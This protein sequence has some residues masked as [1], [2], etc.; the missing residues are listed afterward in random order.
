MK[1]SNTIYLKNNFTPINPLATEET[2]NSFKS[3]KIAH[4]E[5]VSSDVKLD[6]PDNSLTYLELKLDDSKL[7][8]YALA[9][10]NNYLAVGDPEANRVVVYSR[11]TDNNWLRLYEIYPPNNSLEAKRKYGFGY[12]IALHDNLL[13]IYSY[14]YEND[15][16]SLT[17]EKTI[18]DQNIYLTILNHSLSSS[19]TEIKNPK[20]DLYYNGI[21]FLDD[22]VALIAR[23][24]GFFGK[25]STHILLIHP[26]TGKTVKNIKIQDSNFYNLSK[27]DLSSDSDNKSI[28]IL[29]TRYHRLKYNPPLSIIGDGK[30]KKII[31]NKQSIDSVVGI[32]N[33]IRSK[34]I[35]LS[36]DLILIGGEWG[37]GKLTMF[38]SNSSQPYLINFINDYY[39]SEIN[40]YDVLFSVPRGYRQFNPVKYDYNFLRLNRDK[41]ITESKISWS[42][43]VK[44]DTND[45]KVTGLIDSDN[46]LL[47]FYG[48]IVRL[49]IKKLSD[50]QVIKHSNC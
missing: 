22:K 46:L 19:L 11:K 24:K 30:I 27:Y 33:Y 3:L 44:G 40:N 16:G 29:P 39:A 2:A 41:T 13:V 18:I 36:K 31:L 42:C 1:T 15:R 26:Q 14:D 10:S 17:N 50:F 23:I 45:Y 43:P 8:G 7:F 47:S 49:P 21:Q 37:P 38:W 34:I 28:V 25:F 35:R 12:D 20:M 5:T 4:I 32:K 9:V 6:K 48:N